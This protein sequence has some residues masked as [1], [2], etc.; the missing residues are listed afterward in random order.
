MLKNTNVKKALIIAL[1]RHD[2]L[3]GTQNYSIKL[4]NIL[5]E[6]KYE[7]TEYSCD[8]VFE[9]LNGSLIEGINS[10]NNSST[11]KQTHNDFY[12]GKIYL[13]QLKNANK[14]LKE[15]TSKNDYDIIID[16]RQVSKNK[17]KTI[18]PVE[19]KVWVQHVSPAVLEGRGVS[20]KFFEFFLKGYFKNRNFLYPQQNLVLYDEENFNYLDQNKMKSKNVDLIPLSHKKDT[21]A[22]LP[23][24]NF[25]D[26]QFEMGYIGRI[27]DKQK[28]ISFLIKSSKYADTEINIWGNGD[29]KLIKKIQSNTK[30][31]YNGFIEQSKVDVVMENLKFIVVCSRFEGFCYSLVQAMSHGVIPIVLNT[32]PSAKFLT[33]FGFLLDKNIKTKDFAKELNN[34]LKTDPQKLKKLSEQNIEFFNQYLS[35]EQ[36]NKS[37]KNVINKYSK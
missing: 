33:K 16:F 35:E 20:N 4:I 30:T 18:I 11:V 7:I 3:G 22:V 27:E 1:G 23:T 17:K 15:L 21:S 26:R 28:N 36:F 10:I 6:M 12:R 37:W 9:S 32:Y 24:I 31:K 13:R 14:E 29:K 19:N 34:I 8:L 25:L 5:K 2:T